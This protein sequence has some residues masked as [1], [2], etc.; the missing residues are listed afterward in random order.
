MLQFIIVQEKE[1]HLKT[2]AS[3]G[4]SAG[5]LRRWMIGMSAV[6]GLGVLSGIASAFQK[7]GDPPLP[8]A[9]VDGTGL[10][11]KELGQED[12]VR[13]NCDPETFTW[14]GGTVRCTGKPIGALRSVKPYTNFEMVAQWRHL[15]S[16]G[17]SGI[18]VWS[19][20]A[21]LDALKRDQLPEGIEI[22]VLDH[23]YTAQYEKQ[24]GKKAD[25]FTTH[26]D[27]FPVGKSKMTPFEPV[28]PGGSGRSFPRKSLSRKTPEWNH[29][30]IRCI[31]GEV[32]LWVNGE[33]VSGGTD[34]SPRTGHLALESEGAPVEFKNIRLRELP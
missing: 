22:Q 21:T 2:M 26:G 17:N 3:A 7:A 5:T 16:A 18:F 14:N 33:E 27:V 24:T 23:G 12:F 11:W 4:N 32:R 13:V 10:G 8:K 25:W 19:P 28:A 30:Y 31:N 20:R 15:S 29:Y 1:T 6:T 34:C 9:F